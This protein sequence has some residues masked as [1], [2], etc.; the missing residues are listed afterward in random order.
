MPSANESPEG[1]LVNL[2]PHTMGPFVNLDNMVTWTPPAVP[3]SERADH[4]KQQT[5]ISSP[6]P[7][8]PPTP[9]SAPCDQVSHE[10]IYISSDDESTFDAYEEASCGG[11]QDMAIVASIKKRSSVLSPTSKCCC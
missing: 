1:M 7:S 8:L 3:D 9:A 2:L 10:P 6:E 11:S 4:A 5:S